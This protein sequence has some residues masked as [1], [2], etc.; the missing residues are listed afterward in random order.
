MKRLKFAAKQLLDGTALHEH[1]AGQRRQ[2][3]GY[4]Q[5]GED[6][7]I[8]SFYDRL[9]HDRNI[10]V[11]SGCI[12]DIGAFRPIVFSNTYYFYKQGCHTINIDPT[13]KSMRLFNKVRPR[14]TNLELAIAGED[15]KGIFY[16]FDDAPSVW[17]TMDGEAARCATLK[18]GVT[19]RQVEIQC[20]RL[21]TVLDEHLKN[22]ALELL[23]ID[24]EGFDIEILK[25]NNFSKYKPRLILIEVHDTSINNLAKHPV[26]I[27]LYENG[28]Q[29]HSWINP[30]LL[31][32]NND[33][34]LLS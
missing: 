4:S 6:L 7:H 14:D 10:L 8:R 26:I 16:L 21:E 12:V 34:L 29:L 22:R 30:N 27:Y 5:N 23:S 9:A 32:V 1:L 31:F 28:Y 2:R 25:S 15:G 18:I 3:V 17:N 24:A 33:S 20:R 13:P 19:P 11:N